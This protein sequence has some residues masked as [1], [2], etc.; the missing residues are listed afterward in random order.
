VTDIEALLA[1]FRDWLQGGL[2]A[3]PG[4]PDPTELP[5]L[6]AE[7]TALRHDVQLQTKATR[8]LTDK[9]TPP[10]AADPREAQRPLLH[11]LADVA[12]VLRA[13][14]VQVEAVI[15]GPAAPGRGRLARWL[16]RQPAAETSR[17]KAVADGYALSLKRV[18]RALV[19]AGLEPIPAVGERF[20]PQAMEALALGDG[21]TGVVLAESRRGYRWGGEVFRFAGVTVGR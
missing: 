1:D 20:D 8:A 10:P 12:D 15:A 4:S 6:V 18:E 11:T 21:P 14:K 17:L 2:A 16:G 9:L 5:A 19:A 3:G 7:F 13:G